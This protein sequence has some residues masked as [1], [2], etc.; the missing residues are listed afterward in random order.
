[1]V[2]IFSSISSFSSFSGAPLISSFTS[3]TFSV[4]SLMPPRGFIDSVNMGIIISMNLL[5]ESGVT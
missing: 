4:S 3:F 1:M 2:I 5:E